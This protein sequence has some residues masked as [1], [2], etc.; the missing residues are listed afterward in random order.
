MRISA[1]VV[2][3]FLVALGVSDLGGDNSNNV[4]LLTTVDA[5]KSSSAPSHRG[6][7]SSSRRSGSGGGP[8]R[9]GPPP[10]SKP[11]YYDDD[12]YDEDVEDDFDEEEDEE[13]DDMEIDI[14]VDE[15]EFD[16]EEE[17]EEDYRP[18][19]RGPKSKKMASPRR[20]PPPS[21][22]KKR[23]SRPSGGGGPAGRS[24]GSSNRRGD[25][26]GYYDDAG[27]RP[28]K[29][30]ARPPPRSARGRGGPPPPRRGGRNSRV[31]PYTRQPQ[32]PSTFVR[33]MSTLRS[34]MPDPTSVKEATMKSLSVARE[35]TSSLSTNLYREVKGLTSSELEQVMLKATRPDDTPVKGK[36]AER[37]VGLTYQVS[38]Q[39][40]IYDAVLRKLWA[41]MAEK[42]WRTTIK[43]LYILHRFSADGSPQHAQSL[44]LKLRE[45]RRT[46][47]PKRKGKFFSTKILTN[48]DPSPANAKFQ[49][50]SERYAHYVLLRAQAFA[51]MFEEIRDPPPQSAKD[52]RKKAPP[53]PITSTSLRAE[54]L[55]SARKLLN[56]GVACELRKGEECE[57]TAIAVERVAADLLSLTSAVATALT[58]ALKDDNAVKSG[59]D[60]VLLKK[61]CEFYS[62]ELQPK[63]KS[64]VK[65]TTPKL[66]AYGLY[67]PARQK[68]T[69]SPDLLQKGLKLDETSSSSSES[70]DGDEDAA[71]D[72]A[73]D[74]DAAKDGAVDEDSPSSKDEDGKPAEEEPLEDVE[75][76]AVEDLEDEYEYEE[77]EEYYDDEDDEEL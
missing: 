38:S 19:P 10:V 14:E 61:W 42:D 73:A 9:R 55:S 52:R 4:A 6:G 62:E 70:T 56:D 21:K 75:V 25:R 65:K 37:L 36:H 71:E 15:E 41:K 30:G 64:M 11:K 57:N 60:P 48:W 31:V 63:T 22:S 59:A 58:A 45:I 35:T 17:D 46:Q 8:S 51:G 23:P 53:K 54:H 33:G 24:R 68:A 7:S 18:R 29:G 3:L 39:F 69:L 20:G 34:Y 40:E 72:T 32:G 44:K 16:D 13:E 47:D 2:L 76:D 1:G 28:R 67:L 12:E 49:A 26:D 50:F 74:E 27:G 77:E 5:K 43:A 66:D